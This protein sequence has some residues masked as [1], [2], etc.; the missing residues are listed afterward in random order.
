MADI[1]ETTDALTVVMEIEGAD[2]GGP[3]MIRRA[4]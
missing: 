4:V 2:R 3:R 1:Y